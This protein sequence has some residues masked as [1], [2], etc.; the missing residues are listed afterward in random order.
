MSRSTISTFQLLER[1]P[2]ADSARRHLESRLWK[3]GVNCLKCKASRRV[4]AR[5]G[6]FYRCNDWHW[7]FTVRTRTIF[8]RSHVPRQKWPTDFQRDLRKENQTHGGRAL[9]LAQ[10]VPGSDPVAPTTIFNTLR[11]SP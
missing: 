2:D 10:D 4:T 3:D 5:K 7:D 6:E 1:F 9:P 8:E 11:N